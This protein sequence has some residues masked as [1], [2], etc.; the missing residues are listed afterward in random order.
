MIV[1]YLTYSP[2]IIFMGT[3]FRIS[4]KNTKQLT[5]FILGQPSVSV[6]TA[7]GAVAVDNPTG[8]AAHTPTTPPAPY[9]L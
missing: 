5:A 9:R 1:T 2:Y 4:L 7:S 6:S 3:H 8:A